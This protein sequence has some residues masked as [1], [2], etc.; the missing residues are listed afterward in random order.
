MPTSLY[1]LTMPT[2]NRTQDDILSVCSKSTA[3]TMA[4]NKSEEYE[5]RSSPPTKT[6][7]PR[8]CDSLPFQT[9]NRVEN[10][11]F[12]R[13]PR[14]KRQS[15]SP[16]LLYTSTPRRQASLPVRMLK[17]RTEDDDDFGS[18][19]PLP[20][21]RTIQKDCNTRPIYTSAPRR[22]TS[23]P[24]RILKRAVD[25][26][27]FGSAPPPPP[28]TK[29]KDQLDDLEKMRKKRQEIEVA[30][31]KLREEEQQLKQRQQREEERLKQQRRRIR[32][33]N[34]KK[35]QN[36]SKYEVQECTPPD[37]DDD[38]GSR[39][40]VVPLNQKHRLNLST[41]SSLSLGLTSIV[42]EHD[43][44]KDS[45][46]RNVCFDDTEK[47]ET[48]SCLRNDMKKI[49]NRFKPPKLESRPVLVSQY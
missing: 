46:Q 42:E 47:K 41:E 3:K 11:S 22:H 28:R 21:R 31:R 13:P 23:L 48:F 10:S 37:R 5:T 6:F 19:S 45:S 7:A 4:S 27:D 36:S 25:D 43:E 32:R 44:E 40:P 34:R 35:M 14:S 39:F 49:P 16:S 8:R 1:A 20:P 38:K 30:Q 2:S 12:V 33:L 9:L 29:T 24:T 26:D 17:Q 15:Q 18:A